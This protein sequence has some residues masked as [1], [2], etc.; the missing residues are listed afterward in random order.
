LAALKLFRHKG[1]G[2]YHL[3][4]KAA[5]GERGDRCQSCASDVLHGSPAKFRDHRGFGASQAE[6]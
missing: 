1:N 5:A 3:A 4:S 6:R 2:S